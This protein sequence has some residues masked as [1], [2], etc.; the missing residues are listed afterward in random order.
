[1]PEHALTEFARVLVPM[2]YVAL[3]WWQGFSQNRING[4]FFDV[5]KG[6][7]VSTDS[8]PLGP[9]VD[10]FFDEDRFARPCNPQDLTAFG[11]RPSR[12]AYASRC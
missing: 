4:I 12:S 2:G 3:S 7:Y 1:M 5:I 6:L 10:R 11:W 9:S 8:L